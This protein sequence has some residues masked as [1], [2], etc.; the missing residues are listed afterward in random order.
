MFKCH[1]DMGHCFS[2]ELV[3]SKKKE[4]A[5]FIFLYSIGKADKVLGKKVAIFNWEWGRNSAPRE[6][7]EIPCVCTIL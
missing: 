4:K 3:V 1:S 5:K 6:R 7:Q 2:Q